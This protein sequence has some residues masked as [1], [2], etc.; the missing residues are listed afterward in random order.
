[1]PN[2]VAHPAEPGLQET[3]QDWCQDL[4]TKLAQ[5]QTLFRKDM[6]RELYVVFGHE[7]PRPITTRETLAGEIYNV[8]AFFEDKV[9]NNTPQRVSAH[10]QPYLLPIIFHSGRRRVLPE[11]SSITYEPVVVFV[12]QKPTLS[13]PGYDPRTKIYYYNERG[14]DW[15][16]RTGCTHLAKCFE[17]VPFERPEFRN[18]VIGALLGAMILDTK[19]ESPLLCIVGN[20]PGVG[21]TKLSASIGYILTGHEPAPVNFHHGELEKDLGDRFRTGNRFI[22]V[23]NVVSENGTAYRNDR[24][25]TLLTQGHSKRVRE[26]GFSRSVSAE[27]VLFA[28]TMNN[29]ILHEDLAV[30]ALMCK[31][32]KEVTG[33]M[34]TYVLGYAQDHRKELFEELLGILSDTDVTPLDPALFPTFRFR[35]WL[36]MVYPRVLKYFGPMALTEGI[37][38]DS[39]TQEFLGWLEEQLDANPTF[40]LTVEKLLQLIEQPDIQGNR[41][42]LKEYLSRCTNRKGRLI[43]LGIFMKSL[44]NRPVPLNRESVVTVRLMTSLSTRPAVYGFETRFSGAVDNG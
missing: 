14:I 23:D 15:T 4:F 35:S 2:I 41:Q 25:A 22:L 39:A 10:L 8:A 12:D 27:G 1:M 13:Q 17:S 9:I 5:E 18:N 28:L 19:I 31:L 40:T 34:D 32:F 43:S 20:Q 6:D 30:R 38:L 29:C 7:R 3:Q 11:I 42:G 24:L 21:K 26:L 44:C 33:P 36:Q 16:P 37:S